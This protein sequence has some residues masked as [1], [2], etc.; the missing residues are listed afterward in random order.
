MHYY[1]FNV[2]SWAKDTGH[3][4]LKE[5]AIYLR[6]INYYYDYE[7]PIPIK[8]QMVLRKLRMA[9]ESETVDLILEEFFTKTK[10]GWAH[11]HCEKL[12]TEYQKKAE[13]NRKNGKSG[14]RPKI[15]DLEK[16]NGL[17]VETETE[18]SGNLNYKLSTKE[19]LTNNDNKY[20]SPIGES[21]TKKPKSKKV[22]FDELKVVEVWNSL[23]C[24]K[25]TMIT[26]AARGSIEKSY[27]EYLSDCKKSDKEPQEATDW[28]INYLQKG[29][30]NWMT[31]H[32]RQFN[33]GQWSADLEFAMRLATYEKVKATIVT[34]R[35]S[36]G[37]AVVH[38][39]NQPVGQQAKQQAVKLSPSEKFRQMLKAQ[40]R[41]VKF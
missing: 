22:E 30:A 33:D 32:H 5:E 8:T 34:Q 17:Q 23:G 2:S 26:K 20:I 36:T 29:F 16:P 14:G 4:S 28:I 3:L 39:D 27:K 24:I 7:K 37:L 25:H 40:G 1:K 18:P 19:P 38:N 6:L 21:V 13:T 35:T 41:E 15:N 9:D 11:H 31:D 10:E 12:I